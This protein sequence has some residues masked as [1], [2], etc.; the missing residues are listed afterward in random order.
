MKAGDIVPVAKD[1]STLPG[2]VSIHRGELRGVE[3]N[4]MLCSLGE[5][6]LTTH[7]FPYADPDGIFLLQGEDAGTLWAPTS[8]LPSV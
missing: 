6:G 5:L 8:A 1:G 2:G 3:S 7:D 4:G